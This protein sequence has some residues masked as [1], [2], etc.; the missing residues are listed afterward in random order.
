M[1]PILTIYLHP[2][3]IYFF[4]MCNTTLNCLTQENIFR[5]MCFISVPLILDLSKEICMRLSM[6]LISCFMLHDFSSSSC[7]LGYIGQTRLPKARLD[8]HRRK[9][10]K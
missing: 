9:V 7:N 8:E 5:E 2:A 1:F 3:C 6:K 4:V 10:K